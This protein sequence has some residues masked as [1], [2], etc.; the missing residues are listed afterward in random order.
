LN[1]QIVERSVKLPGNGYLDGL[2]PIL[3]R[4]YKARNIESKQQLDYA[5]SQ[6]P[7]PNLLGGMD[8]MVGELVATLRKQS[9]ILIVADFD[10]DGATSCVVAKLGLE[11]MGANAVSYAVPN[12]FEYG[13]GLTPEIVDVALQ[14]Q[15]DVIVTV[16]NGISSLDGVAYAKSHGLRVLVTDHHLPGDVLP[17]A[18]AIV[19]PNL[20]GDPFPSKSLAGVGVMFYVLSALRAELRDKDWFAERGIAE[21]N[22]AQLLDLVALGTVADVVPLDHVNR[23][24]I[25]H[26]LKRI[27]AAKTHVGIQ[28]IIEVAGRSITSLTAADLGFVVGP[29]LNAAGRLEDMSTGIECLLSQ[30]YA[31]A[32]QLANRLDT[33]NS[34]RREIEG[35]MKLEAMSFLESAELNEGSLVPAGI[36]LYDANW[37]QGI[38]GIL[39][40][41]IKDR[42]NRPVIA[43]APADEGT[44][45]GSARSVEGVHMRDLLSEI[46][47]TY[48]ALLDRFGGHAMAAGL[49]LDLTKF[50]EFSAVFSQFVETKMGAENGPG[51]FYSDG[52]LTSNLMTLEIADLIRQSGP[53]GH[54]FPE[55]TFHGEFEVV[56]LRIL[57]NQ[58]LKFVLKQPNYELLVDGIAFFVDDPNQWLDCEFVRLGY[59]LSV[60]EF[61]DVRSSQ[62]IV[63]QIE[64]I[65]EAN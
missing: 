35:R 63:E 48:P 32:R 3:R 56:Q 12:R 43:F 42:F 47:S 20:P 27:K 58:H 30:D 7:H 64:R 18:N 46:A 5:L 54:K 6:L 44:L 14:K 49:S 41:R 15:P 28:A 50:D 9:R 13:Y 55:P 17:E 45:K 23:V 65:G 11:M 29:R 51:I 38:V 40:S 22:L 59:R 31:D 53:W 52:E 57:K 36:C 4:V 37:H 2:H 60:N 24:F 8:V 34:E 21:P 33:L 25:H 61:R 16:D 62:I 39:A 26:G 1:K 19:N 10:T